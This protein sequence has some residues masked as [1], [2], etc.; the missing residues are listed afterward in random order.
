MKNDLDNSVQFDAK[1]WSTKPEIKLTADFICGKIYKNGDI[2]LKQKRIK[3]H[4]K[5]ILTNLFVANSA[6]HKPY[7]AV[8]MNK[9]QYKMCRRY[10]KLYLSYKYMSFLI[11][12]L[13]ELGYLELH[14][15]INFHNF[16]RN[17]RIKATSKLVRLFRKY[18]SDIGIIFRRCVPIVL[19]DNDK[20]DIDFD[21]NDWQIKEHIVNVNKINKCLSLHYVSANIPDNEL[22]EFMVEFAK[23]RGQDKYTRVF[24]NSD[25]ESGGRF[26]RHWTQGV[27]SKFRKYI[28]IDGKPTVE[29]DYSCLHLSMLYGLEGMI[30][31]EGDLYNLVGMDCKYRPIIK[32]AVNI[33]INAKDERSTIQAIRQ[34]YPGFIKEH[35]HTPPS[36]KMILQNIK[37]THPHIQKY[38]CSNYG[39]NLQYLDSTIAEKILLHFA[40]GNICCLSIHDSF[41]IQSSYREELHSLMVRYFQ[42]IFHFT[43]R[44]SG[45]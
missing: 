36:P 28:T 20:N 43:P 33:A 34:E 7:V 41:I 12:I 23:Y 32:K 26:Y 13:V 39:V 17:S 42:E 1:W 40:R 18:K 4:L 45:K 11:P 8:S 31:P 22:Y 3:N 15:G 14:K 25:W 44:I 29:L 38:L 16:K 27:K 6:K 19:R 21:I 37:D 35:G 10:P 24:N 2:C 9:S 30:P 5:V